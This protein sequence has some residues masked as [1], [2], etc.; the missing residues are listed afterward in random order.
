MNDIVSI[1]KMRPEPVTGTVFGAGTTCGFAVGT[2]CGSDSAE[3]LRE[4]DFL[5]ANIPV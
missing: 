5:G 2:S 4:A 3:T 1:R